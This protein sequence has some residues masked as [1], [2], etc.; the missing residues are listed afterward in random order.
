MHH[1]PDEPRVPDQQQSTAV[2]HLRFEDVSQ[3]GQV[4]LEALPYGLGPALWT[5]LIQPS[6]IAPL[7][8]AQ[9]VI[10]ILT[11]L[12]VEG[13]EGPIAVREPLSLRGLYQLAHTVDAAGEVNRLVLC[14]WLSATGRR[15]RTYGPPPKGAGETIPIGRVFAEHVFT[16]PFA[17]P[18]DRKVLR[19]ESP[20]L[21]AVPPER[22]TWR[23]PEALM[24]LPEGAEP[25]DAEPFADPTPIAFGFDHTDQNQHVN[26]LVYP[27]LFADAVFRRLAAH[28]LGTALLSRSVE[29]AYR[30]PCFAGIRARILLRTFTLG[31]A[32]GALGAFIP[33]PSEDTAGAAPDARAYCYIRTRFE[34]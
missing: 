20:E 33:E 34:G 14:M 15:S 29:I 28:G 9:G 22:H 31:G 1:I 24:G 18:E 17:A 30:K 32:V 19:L 27:R 26:S 11:R 8:S 23:S 2:M 3:N 4:M 12:V 6:P 16:R 7:M 25:L 21:P 13:G 10:P 5:K